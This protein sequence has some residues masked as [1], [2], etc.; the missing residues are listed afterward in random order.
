MTTPYEGSPILTA[1]QLRVVEQS[2][3]SKILVTAGA[4]SG[5]THTLVRRLDALMRRDLTGDVLVLTFSRAAVRELGDRLAHDGEAA[6]HVRAQTFDSWALGLLTTLNSGEDWQGRSF[7]DR[8]SA[9]AD[10]VADGLADDLYADDLSHVVIDEIQDLVGSRRALV[11][12]LLDRY[13]CGFTVVGDLA[14]AIYGF[15]VPRAERAGEA[16]RFVQWLRTTFDGELIELELTENFRAHTKEARVALGRGSVLQGLTATSAAEAAFAEIRRDLRTDL[17]DVMSIGGVG[18]SHVLDALRHFD[19]TCAILCRT[20]G[21]ALVLSEILR[22]GHVPHRV[23]S[24]NRSRRTPAWIAD[25]Y[26]PGS[27]PLLRRDD[28]DRI[29]ASVESMVVV[30]PESAWRHLSRVAGSAGGHT[31]DRARLR[32]ALRGNRLPDELTAPPPAALTVSSIHRAK[33]LEFDR[34]IVL[35]PDASWHAR[36][37]D[38]AEEA[39]L[40]YVAMTRAREDLVRM[41]GPDMRSV[42]IKG[43]SDRWGRFG[44]KA[45][46]RLGMEFR[47]ED[48]DESTPPGTSGFDAVPASVQAYLRTKVAPGDAVRLDRAG[49]SSAEAGA[50]PDYIISHEG[51]PI[52]VTSERFRG[53]LARF[54]PRRYNGAWPVII[55]GVHVDALETTAGNEAAGTAAGLGEYG[56]WLAPR[57]GGLSRF[58]YEQKADQEGTDA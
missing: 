15:Q 7:D 45:W 13:D 41:P 52:A 54:M 39:R 46:Q 17:L 34:V 56:V 2:A 24:S 9:A 30:D 32:S 8:I 1:E 28:F 48:V 35:E 43:P 19:G 38:V 33:G 16:G 11:E 23:Q 58:Q 29:M 51:T 57:I 21:Q 42:Y 53:E 47:S 31:L 12:S 18:E 55:T 10:V 26:P 20:N 37:E 44:W 25:L 4:G 6:R 3:D 36:D 22:D 49:A 40:A 14:Q 5:K 50:V 27:G